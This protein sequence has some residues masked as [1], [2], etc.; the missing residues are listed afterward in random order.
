MITYCS[1][2]ASSPSPIR[3]G[4]VQP[5]IWPSPSLQMPWYIMVLGHQQAQCLLR[6]LDKFLIFLNTFSLSRQHYSK[7]PLRFHK[8]P[9]HFWVLTFNMLNC[10]KDYK[11][12]T[13]IMNWILDLARPKLM[14]LTLEQQCMLSVLH[15][16]YHAWWCPGDLVSQDIS[17]H[18]IDPKSQNIP[19]PA[20][21]ELIYNGF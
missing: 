7:W 3:P 15:V 6:K 19:S 5:Q 10:L 11:R 20:S 16:E 1:F 2:D 17:R 13:D 8:I 18:G 4:Y 12:Y 21:E 14:E 9:Q